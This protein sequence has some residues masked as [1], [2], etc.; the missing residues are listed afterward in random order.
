MASVKELLILQSSHQ[1]DNDETVQQNLANSLNMLAGSLDVLDISKASQ[2]FSSLATK[3]NQD[4]SSFNDPKAQQDMAE[5]LAS[6]EIYLENL[7]QTGQADE[8][9]LQTAL[10]TLQHFGQS[11]EQTDELQLPEIDFS[12]D[13]SI[14]D[15]VS[16]EDEKLS[17]VDLY[18]RSLEDKAADI[19]ASQLSIAP[20]DQES[21]AA[22]DISNSEEQVE[23][24]ELPEID[25]S[26]DDSSEAP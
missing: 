5:I 19:D 17:S 21:F 7:H 4:A 1:T 25:F 24:L 10:Q 13:K 26:A 23:A 18:L 6:A 15:E 2:L 12:A 3:F 16:A 9:I 8:N 22:Q 14:E 20:P 11:T